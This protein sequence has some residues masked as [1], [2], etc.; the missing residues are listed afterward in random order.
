MEQEALVARSTES[1]TAIPQTDDTYRVRFFGGP[2]AGTTGRQL[3]RGG[4]EDH[5]SRDIEQGARTVWYEHT[6]ETAEYAGVSTWHY[7]Y[8]GTVLAAPTSRA[9]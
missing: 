2:L 5:I 8:E 6:G 4:A 3:S 9:R 1:T 7:A